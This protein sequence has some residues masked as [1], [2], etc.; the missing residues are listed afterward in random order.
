MKWDHE[1]G[2]AALPRR[3]AEQQ[4]GPT[5]H[6]FMRSPGWRSSLH[7]AREP[8]RAQADAPASWSAAALRR[9]AGDAGTPKSARGLAHSKPW[10]SF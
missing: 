2:R 10:P 1:P 8:E 6:R 3:R 5:M 7:L 9:F 4:L